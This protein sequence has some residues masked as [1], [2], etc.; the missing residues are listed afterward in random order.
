MPSNLSCPL[1]R[2]VQGRAVW[3]PLPLG[4]GARNRTGYRHNATWL[5]VSARGRGPEYRGPVSDPTLLI[6][7]ATLVDGRGDILHDVGIVIVGERIAAV[8][9][10]AAV[11]APPDMPIL[12]AMRRTVLPGLID[13]HVHVHGEGGAL[14]NWKLMEA[15]ETTPL[16]A[17]RAYANGQKHLRM[18]Y[19]ALR[20]V[21]SRGYV[22]VALRDAIHQGVVQGP[23]LQVAGQG[24]TITGGHMDK[25]G[26]ADTVAFSG[27]TGVIDGPWSGRQAVRQQVKAGA[28]L[29]KINACG[30]R[31][32]PTEPWFQEMTLEEMQA[33]CDEAHK[34]GRRVA[35]HTSGGPTIDDCLTAGVDSIEHGHWLTDAQLDHMAELGTFYVPTLIV[36]SRNIQLGRQ[37]SGVS[38]PAWDW[39]QKV[40]DDK[41]DTL[42]RARRAGVK[43]AAGSDAGFLVHHGEGACELEEMVKGG[44]T[45]HEA[46]LAATRVAADCMGWQDKVGAVEVGKLADLV[47]VDG[48][49]LADIT[50]LQRAECITTVVKGGKVVA[51]AAKEG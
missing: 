14:V 41:W 8:E 34:L 43:I 15:T 9:P 40:Y 7:A 28:D 44:F 37:A 16:T 19:T 6:H 23:R 24:L 46:I 31:F 39:L 33:I 1:T 4:E 47:I 45:P 18:G 3:F 50:L 51:G 48:D 29:I 42:T 25:G 2:R 49:P 27:R 32:H 35:A 26:W 17:L 30:G 13:V 36:N 22:D 10:W 38:G 20:D 12:D 11:V 21:A 5:P